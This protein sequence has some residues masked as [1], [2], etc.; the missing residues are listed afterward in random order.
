[1]TTITIDRAT[2]EQALEAMLNFPDDISDAMFESITALK[3]ALAQKHD[4]VAHSGWVLRE[5]LFDN[6]E[7]IGHR[8]P[9]HSPAALA[10][11]AEPL[12]LADPAVQKRLASQWGYVP[13]AAQAEPV[14]VAERERV[15]SQWD[16]CVTHQLDTFGPVDIGASIRAGEL[17]EA[18]QDS[19]CLHGVEDGACKE[20]YAT[21]TDLSRCPQCNGPADN[22]FDRS[23]PPSPYLCT[24]CMAEPVEPVAY[25]GSAYVNENGVHITTVLGPVAIPQDAKLYTAPPQRT[26][27]PLTEEEIFK[28]ENDIPDDVISDRAWTICL[29]RAV[30]KA[31]WEKNHGQA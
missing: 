14:Q 11:Q 27:V 25:F 15:A 4:P 18:Q 7:P 2:V 6:G 21:E 16:G 9:Q 20:C 8:E 13:A 17:V 12:N 23:F 1:M 29:T 19:A 22:G 5:V 30:E 28:I 10:Q 26:M 3:A 31:V 24:K